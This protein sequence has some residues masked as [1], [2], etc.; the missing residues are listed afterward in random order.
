MFVVFL[1]YFNYYILL[2]FYSLLYAFNEVYF[3]KEFKKIKL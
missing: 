3:V 1:N 2:T